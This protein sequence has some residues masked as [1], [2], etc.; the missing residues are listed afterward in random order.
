[1][2]VHAAESLDDLADGLSS[3]GYGPALPEI[4]GPEM[5]EHEVGTRRSS[6]GH[7]TVAYLVGSPPAVSFVLLIEVAVARNSAANSG[8]GA[9]E[10]GGNAA[11]VKELPEIISVTGFSWSGLG[12]GVSQRHD[13]NGLSGG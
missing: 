8:H 3:L 2:R 12:N 1:M 5:D 10:V 4:V 7:D 9:H 6:P 13:A 11:F